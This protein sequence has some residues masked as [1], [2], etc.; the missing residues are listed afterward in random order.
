[1]RKVL[2]VILVS[3]LFA[4]KKISTSFILFVH[5]SY[6]PTS[7]TPGCEGLNGCGRGPGGG[8]WG[9]GWN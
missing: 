9:C 8:V 3:L 7:L 6:Q 1:M 4:H 5:L 2:I